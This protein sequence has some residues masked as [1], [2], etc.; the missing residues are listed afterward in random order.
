MKLEHRVGLIVLAA[1][2]SFGQS[3]VYMLAVG[4]ALLA[5]AFLWPDKKEE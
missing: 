2:M 5:V 1:L 4:I 3:N